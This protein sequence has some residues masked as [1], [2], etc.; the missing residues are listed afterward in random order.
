VGDKVIE[1]SRS[2]YRSDRYSRRVE[3]GSLP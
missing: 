3:L 2:V 1:V